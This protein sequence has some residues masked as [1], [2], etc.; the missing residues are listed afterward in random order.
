MLTAPVA[1]SS[2]IPAGHTPEVA[3]VALPAAPSVAAKPFTVSLAATLATGVD[4]VPDTALPLS[5]AGRMAEAT[6][7]VTVLVAQ[8]AGLLVSHNWYVKV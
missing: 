2:V 3:T 5:I 4:A 6:V 7:T 8:F 1:G